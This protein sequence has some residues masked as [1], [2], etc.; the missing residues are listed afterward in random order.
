MLY[1][2]IQLGSGAGDI[3]GLAGSESIE[4]LIRHASEESAPRLLGSLEKATRAA[5]KQG[6]SG[7]DFLEW[8]LEMLEKVVARKDGE[9]IKDLSPIVDIAKAALEHKNQAALPAA[10]SLLCEGALSLPWLHDLYLAHKSR[11]CLIM[12][13]PHYSPYG[14]H[15]SSLLAEKMKHLR[16]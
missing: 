13:L 16:D 8:G 2:T 10:L 9:L 14:D 15:L 12:M 3:R 1:A 7:A 6:K 5:L 4:E 11:G